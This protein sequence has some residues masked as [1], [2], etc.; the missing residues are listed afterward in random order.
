MA[1]SFVKRAL[2]VVAGSIAL[3]LGFVAAQPGELAVTRETTIA[4]PVDL[5][6]AYVEDFRRW[7]AWSPWERAG[8]DLRRELAGPPAGAGATYRWDARGESNAGSVTI[9]EVVPLQKVTIELGLSAPIQTTGEMT[10]SLE[11]VGASTRLRWSLRG[12]RSF[13]EK[14]A[15]LGSDVPAELSSHLELG[16]AALARVSEADAAR[17]REEMLRDAGAAASAE[18][19]AAEAARRRGAPSSA[20]ASPE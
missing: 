7:P 3:A 18:A 1:G 12:R 8:T 15:S 20:T 10:F 5:V 16:L 13:R 14:L 9:A 6:I 4:A 19:A 17:W 2:L 11:P